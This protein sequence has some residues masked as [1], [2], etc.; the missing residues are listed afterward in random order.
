MES[1]DSSG[2]FEREKS[3]ISLSPSELHTSYRSEEGLNRSQIEL[4]EEE[5]DGRVRKDVQVIK[6]EFTLS[7]LLNDP[8]ELEYFKVSINIEL[9]I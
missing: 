3:F 6:K 7:N 4:M 8:K 9:Y 2:V 1:V 5:S